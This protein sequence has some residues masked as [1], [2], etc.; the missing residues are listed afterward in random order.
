MLDLSRSAITVALGTWEVGPAAIFEAGAA[1]ALDVNGQVGVAADG[2][3][4]FGVAKWNKTTA[5]T[6]VIVA[7]PVVLTLFASSNLKHADLVDVSWIVTNAAGTPWTN[8]ADYVINKTNGT[9]H[10]TDPGSSIPSGATVYVTYRYNLTTKDLVYAGRNYMNLLDDTLGSGK[11]TVIQDYAV[12]FIDQF[13]TSKAYATSGATSLLTVDAGK[14]RPATGSEVVVAKVIAVP[15]A[16][17]QLLGI[18]LLG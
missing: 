7:E 17:D 1:V 14:F 13:D 3:T 18:M 6:A 10:R 8:A 5:L 11:I 9:I 15:T 4:F 12:L 16:S 2:A